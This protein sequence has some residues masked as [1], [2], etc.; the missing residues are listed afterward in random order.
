MRIDYYI[1]VEG[2]IDKLFIEKLFCDKLSLLGKNNFIIEYSK[3]EKKKIKAFITSIDKMENAEYIFLADQDGRQD[4]KQKILNK[5]PF[6]DE[7]KVFISIYEIESWII[8]GISQRLQKKYKIKSLGNDT[9]KITKE[10]FEKLIP[11]SVDKFEFI[12]FLI[13]DY[14]ID[15]AILLNKSL[16]IFYNYL[17]NKKAS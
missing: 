17:K 2:A 16:N 9:S 14:N 8:S 5:Y 7:R 10:I 6:L 11:K 12:A 1:F 15:S 4:K 3:K 13:D